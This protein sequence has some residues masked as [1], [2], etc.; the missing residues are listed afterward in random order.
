MRQRSL[1]IPASV[2]RRWRPTG[3]GNIDAERVTFA[4]RSS[5]WQYRAVSPWRRRP[6]RGS[7][8]PCRRIRSICGSQH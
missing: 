6:R 4:G 2:L 1:S 3:F 7:R 8:I 5:R